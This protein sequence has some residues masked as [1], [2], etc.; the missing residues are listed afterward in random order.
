[1]TFL[2][3]IPNRLSNKTCSAVL[4]FISLA[5]SASLGASTPDQVSTAQLLAAPMSFEANQGQTVDSVRFLS[6]GPGYTLFLTPREAVLSLRSSGTE[7]SGR[8]QR[9]PQSKMNQ[10]CLTMTFVGANP[11]PEVEGVDQLAGTANYFIGNDPSQWRTAVPTYDKVKYH[12]LYPGVDLIYYGNQRQVEYDFVIE[13]K[14][15]PKRIAI[16][17]SGADKLEVDSEGGLIAHLGSGDI[18]W[19]KPLAYQESSGGKVEVSVKFVLKHRREIA[20]EIASYDTTK[21]LTIDPV[22]VYA[23]YLGGNKG[24]FVSG[25]A[26]DAA[27]SPYIIGDTTSLNFPTAS[28]FRT[29]S[30]G[31]N[32]VFVT[33]LNTTGSGLIYST[34]LGG[35]SNDFAGGIALD[36]SGNAYLTGETGSPDFPTRNAAYPSNA[37]FKDA[38][39][40]KLGPFGTNLIYSTYLGGN[41]DD[42]GRAIAV[43]SG[44]NVYVT[45]STYSKGSGNG[46]FPTTQGAYQGNNGGG[47]AITSDAFVTKFNTN[48]LLSYST[49]LGGSTDEKANGIAIDSS[50]NAYI[51]GEVAS[52]PTFPT[53]PS[54]DFP[55]VNAFQSSFNQGNLDP[56]AGNTDGFL[57]KLNATGTGLIFSTFLGGNDQDTITGIALDSAG[58][59]HVTGI[60]GSTNFPTVNAAQPLNAGMINDPDFPLTDAFVSKFETNG[61]SLLYSTYLGG[62]LDESPFL[63]DRFGI[64]VDKFGDIYVAGQTAS[65]DFPLTTGADQTNSNAAEDAFIG[66][67][68]PAVHGPSSLIYS[69]LLSGSTGVLPG[70]ADN[71]GGPIAVDNNGNF[72]VAGITSSTN[73]PVTA[74]ALRSTN[75]GGGYDAFVAKFSSPAD[76]S[77][78]MTPSVEPVIIGSNV[79]YTILVNNNGRTTFSGVS[80]FVQF[81]TNVRLGPISSTLGSFSTNSNGLVTFNIGTLT[82]NASVLQTI[83]ITNLTAGFY[84][85]TATVTSIETPSLELNTDNNIAT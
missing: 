76:L 54:S 50:G 2:S 6:R 77:V 70:G 48:G 49:F 83:T 68:N 74:G 55:L 24:D 45:G 32:E 82:N 79:T 78:A 17:F 62:T 15:D 44:G 46:P 59:V 75:G 8:G 58:R 21:P 27:G 40:T 47:N 31:S 66:K 23:T 41:G 81:T 7:S 84:T 63:L 37:G 10:A 64:A 60:T 43:D 53:P 18:R 33:K 52:Y 57:T 65:F 56:F 67:I 34:Y 20:F 35:S 26:A 51:V 4:A 16:S 22:L 71:E 9:R 1:M 42:S 25:I 29:T 72:Y 80:N 36:G 38:F 28:A 73:F 14:A 61:S 69:T 85:N 13:P 12:D 39:V 3:Q 5:A 30:A 19:K 11:R